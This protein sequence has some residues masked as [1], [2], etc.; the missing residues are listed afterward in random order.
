[1]GRTDVAINAC[2]DLTL[3]SILALITNNERSLL[4]TVFFDLLLPSLFLLSHEIFPVKS[5]K[6][7]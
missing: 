3:K 6:G 5:R 7:R 2:N 1:M 4:I